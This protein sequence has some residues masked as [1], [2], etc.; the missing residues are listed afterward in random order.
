MSVL[1]RPH[2]GPGSRCP[3]LNP[4][5]RSSSQSDKRKPAV[6]ETSSGSVKSDFD[7]YRRSLIGLAPRFDRKD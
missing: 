1:G 2:F 4:E 7:D 5:F 3:R 6:R